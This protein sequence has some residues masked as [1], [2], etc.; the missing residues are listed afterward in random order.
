M[1]RTSEEGANEDMAQK[2][3]PLEKKWGAVLAP[4]ITGRVTYRQL[5][6]RVSRDG[7]WLNLS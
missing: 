4:R 3:R 1:R 7:T 6:E 2:N 5:G